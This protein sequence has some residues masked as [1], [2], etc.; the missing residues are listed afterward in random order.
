MNNEEKILSILEQI[1][2]DVAGLKSDVAELK[3][4][5]A[6]LK[7]DV[8]EL[9]YDVKNLK[10]AQAE[11]NRRLDKIE[12][13]LSDNTEITIT[14]SKQVGKLTGK[15]ADHDNKFKGLREA[16]DEAV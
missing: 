10:Q 1:Q 11:T 12:R 14:L 16:L 7:S 5:V 2:S 6:E 9:K 8:A 4:D 15:I 3:S 13:D